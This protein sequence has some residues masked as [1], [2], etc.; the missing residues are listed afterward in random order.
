MVSTPNGKPVCVCIGCGCDDDHAC[1]DLLDDPC[2]WLVQSATGKHGVCTECALTLPSWMKGKR[3]LTERAKANI[4][5]RKLRER[6][7]RP[8][9]RR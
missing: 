5:Q 9:V 2:G 6:L 4:A 3:Q 8:K 7:S 1:A